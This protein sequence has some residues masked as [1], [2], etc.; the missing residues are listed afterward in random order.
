MVENEIG[1]I[2]K[3][4]LQTVSYTELQYCS[5]CKRP[6]YTLTYIGVSDR[7]FCGRCKEEID[8]LIWDKE[9]LGACNLAIKFAKDNLDDKEQIVITRDEV[10][11]VYKDETIERRVPFDI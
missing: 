5:K 4:G 6:T 8:W 3:E 1:K 7:G 11:I 10:M 9:L 2:E